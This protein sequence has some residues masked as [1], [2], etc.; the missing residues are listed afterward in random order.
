MAGITNL[1]LCMAA[2]TSSLNESDIKQAL[3]STTVNDIRDWTE[4]NIDKILLQK[5]R[6]FFAKLLL[7]IIVYIK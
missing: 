3:E 6:N 2:F 7:N 5:R 4:K 1:A